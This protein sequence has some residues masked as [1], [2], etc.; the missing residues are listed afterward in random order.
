MIIRSIW[1]F[2]DHY[3]SSHTTHEHTDTHKVDDV[4]MNIHVVIACVA[5][6]GICSKRWKT[7]KYS[8]DFSLVQGSKYL[9]II[10]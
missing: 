10:L 9:M 8:L 7:I 6:G 3:V 4:T 1:C 2:H 5:I